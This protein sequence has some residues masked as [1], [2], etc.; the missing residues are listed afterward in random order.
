MLPESKE[1]IQLDCTLIL[2]PVFNDWEAA[3]LLLTRLDEA[4]HHKRI[5]AE[6]L[7]IDDA[8][9]IAMAQNEFVLPDLKSIQKVSV[10]ELRRNFGHQRAIALGLAYVE[11]N[12]R[13]RAVAVMDGDGE[14]APSDVPRLLEKCAE[15]GYSKMIFGQRSKRAENLGFRSFYVL[16]RW[17]YKLLTGHPIRV[18]NFSVIPYTV[19]RRLVAVSEVWNHFAAGALK[20]RVPY[21][22]IPTRRGKRLTGRSQM[23]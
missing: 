21:C 10:I 22:E 12:T 15:E 13:C 14:D 17:L 23:N 7:L 8:S 9:S 1:N 6:V 5:Q 2:I 16:Y 11:A 4:L 18:G 3:F 20:A 19:L